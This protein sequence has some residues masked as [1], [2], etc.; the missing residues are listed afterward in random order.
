MQAMAII[1]NILGATFKNKNKQI[2]L[3]LVIYFI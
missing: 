3:I 2:K 1:L